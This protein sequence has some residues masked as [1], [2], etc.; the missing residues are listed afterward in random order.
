MSID[1]NET[2]LIGSWIKG[3]DRM[4]EDEVCHRIDALI[5]TEL[6]KVATSKSGWETLYRN[7]QDARYGSFIVH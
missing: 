7:P 3:D 5:R 1:Q 6:V 2:D 4:I